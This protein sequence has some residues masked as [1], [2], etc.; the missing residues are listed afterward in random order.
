MVWQK[1]RSRLR[2]LLLLGHNR[3]VADSL[4]FPLLFS[5]GL[6]HHPSSH[7][8][9]LCQVHRRQVLQGDS[10]SHGRARSNRRH[11]NP[12][13][14]LFLLFDERRSRS[15]W[16]EEHSSSDA[17]GSRGDAERG[18]VDV[19]RWNHSC[20]VEGRDLHAVGEAAEPEPE[21]VSQVLL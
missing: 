14:F 17:H 5:S 8:F 16:S 6:N 1:V 3:R 12:L 19:E 15:R 10:A 18:E 2:S 9:I 20:R 21:S 11:P 7:P 13:H 4:S